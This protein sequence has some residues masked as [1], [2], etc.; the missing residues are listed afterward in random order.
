M[1][2]SRDIADQQDN[3][4][5]AVAPFV[6]GKNKIINGDMFWNQRNF[7]SST[8]LTAFIFDRFFTDY[9]DGTT[10]SSAET[11][12]PGTAPVAGYEAANFA[13]LVTTGQTLASAYSWFRHRIENVRTLA[14]QT[15]TVSFWAKAATGTPKITVELAQQFGAGGS[16]Q[17]TTYFGQATLSTSWQRFSF[18]A[19]LPSL[20]GKTI[21][22]SSSLTLNLMVSAGS[23]YNAR[24]NSMGIQSNT[25]DIWGVQ[26]EAG[27]VAT[28]FTP[29]GG[30]FPGAELALCQ[31]Y[32]Y[33]IVAAA[34]L[35][36]DFPVARVAT[37][38]AEMTVYLPVPLRT[39][40]SLSLVAVGGVYGRIVG[41]DN[42]F[43]ATVVNVT[44]V[45]LGNSAN[46]QM[47]TI[48]FTH[49]SMT[50]TASAASTQFDTANAAS[51]IAL[52]AEL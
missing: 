6:A 30:G 37:T 50:T 48:G 23:D 20:S 36:F 34:A 19:L 52:S 21:G 4:G 28:P 18:T 35:D 41:F 8:A 15:T 39:T 51:T 27:S 7:T 45:G 38:L 11:F 47:I 26:L 5:G 24:T 42:S 14:N 9:S 44:S 16:S 17:V 10:T 43:A 32:Y 40:P 49:S 3:L 31:R 25:F 22:T 33:P 2:R 1:T 12:T 29:A 13:R 46:T